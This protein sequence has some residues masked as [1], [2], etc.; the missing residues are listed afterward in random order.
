[1][2]NSSRNPIGLYTIGIVGLFLAGFFLLVIFGAQSY[3]GTVAS[4]DENRDSRAVLAYVS[5]SIRNND[6]K[7]AVSV[8]NG[9]IGDT[10]I[11]ADTDTGYALRI[12]LK[13]GE[14][15]ED[16]GKT[17]SALDPENAEKIGPC[18][19]FDCEMLRPDLLKVVTD[20][21]QVMINLRSE[22]R[23]GQ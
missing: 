11:I 3:Q 23:S 16:L 12:Y 15:M 21:G 6:M 17:G 19:E 14:L 1:M 13:D 20:R 9:D 2:K 4:Q 22:E 5:T 10:L 7:G 8:E 18:E